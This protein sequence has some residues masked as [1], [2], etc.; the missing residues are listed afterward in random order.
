M[1]RLP[2]PDLAGVPQHVIQRGNDRKPCFVDDDDR[3]RYLQALQKTSS[4]Y[5]C[6]IHAF[7]LMTNHVHLLVTP[8]VVGSVSRMMQSI[9][10]SHVAQ[11]NLRHER[12]GTLWEGRYKSCLVDT[13]IY[14]L[15]CYR[16]I[17]LNPLRAA[18]VDRPSEYRWSSYSANCGARPS[19]LVHPHDAYLALGA[20][21]VD[22][23]H[24][25]RVILGDA[26]PEDQLHEIRRYTQQQRALGTG[27]FQEMVQRELGRCAAV[28]PAHRP[29][30]TQKAL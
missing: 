20:T 6:A 13:E 2:R 23:C 10:R 27:R 7:V 16:Y 12:T 29:I 14:V 15:A 3:Y 26:M 4:R 24:A 18:L 9:G 22:R 8:A 28:R 25:Y 5:G 21:A 17:E 30:G 11:F 19:T 1:S